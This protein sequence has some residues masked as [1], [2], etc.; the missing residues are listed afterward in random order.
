MTPGVC[1]QPRHV[2]LLQ[3]SY[4][5]DNNIILPLASCKPCVYQVCPTVI[6]SLIDLLLS[7]LILYDTLLPLQNNIIW[8]KSVR[9]LSVSSILLVTVAKLL[10]KSMLYHGFKSISVFMSYLF[11]HSM[12]P[13][14]SLVMI[15]VQSFQRSLMDGRPPLILSWCMGQ[16]SPISVT[17]ALKWWALKCWCVSGTW[18]GAETCPPV[19][20]V[21]ATCPVTIWV[22]G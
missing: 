8:E 15:R 9:V 4:W 17:Q 6:E 20:E 1:G 19:R 10:C 11:F 12:P 2:W 22:L 13:Q 16:W 18:P 7:F 3:W 5:T 14:R 21:L